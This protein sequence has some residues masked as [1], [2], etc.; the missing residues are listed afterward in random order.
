MKK[1]FK[2]AL[3]SGLIFPGAGQFLLKRYIRGMIFFA[4]SMAALVYVVDFVMR[5]ATSIVEQIEQGTIPLEP[6][7][8]SQLLEG[9]SKGSDLYLANAVQWVMLAIWA[10]S[11]IDAYRLG[12]IMEQSDKE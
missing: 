12:N 7:S 6:V 11:L 1:S 5:K 2:A 10:L 9:S 4:P 8:L 3:Y